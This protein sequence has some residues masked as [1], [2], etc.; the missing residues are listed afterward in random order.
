[1]QDKI[2]TVTVYA[3]SG[4]QIDIVYFETA[5]ELGY[6]PAQYQITCINGAGNQ[7]LMGEVANAGLKKNGK[8]IG[9]ISRKQ[10]SLYNCPIIIS[11]TNS[12]YN[13]LLR[14]VT[15]NPEQVLAIVSKNPLSIIA[16]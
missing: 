8:A 3:A 13:D 2:R 6:L 12:Y 16:L 7:G 11:S 4:S 15:E 5:K 9:I 10:L 14:H 1:M